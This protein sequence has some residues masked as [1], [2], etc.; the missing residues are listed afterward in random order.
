VARSPPHLVRQADRPSFPKQ[1]TGNYAEMN[2][3]EKRNTLL[4]EFKEFSRAL[5]GECATSLIEDSFGGE[6]FCAYRFSKDGTRGRAHK[7]L[8]KDFPKDEQLVA[9]MLP[10]LHRIYTH[11]AMQTIH[12][13][14]VHLT[15]ELL[16]EIYAQASRGHEYVL[17]E[18]MPG[19]INDEGQPVKYVFNKGVLERKR[20]GKP[21][22]GPGN[23]NKNTKYSRAKLEKYI[24][25]YCE[26]EHKRPTREEAR[27]SLINTRASISA[28][29]EAKN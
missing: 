18:Y 20:V 15:Q 9:S 22:R 12:H 23:K 27:S 29:H 10:E 14:L 19:F 5:L 24:R 11:K 2:K 1:T 17:K 21:G 26:V 4:V 25:S 7:Q 6:L 8:L 16:A 13:A 3:W 28:W